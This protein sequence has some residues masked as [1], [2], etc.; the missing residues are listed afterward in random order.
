[1]SGTNAANQPSS[2][3]TLRTAAPS[4]VPGG[5]Q[6]SVS[7]IDSA[8]NFWFGDLWKYSAGEWTWMSGSN[9]VPQYGVYGTLGTPDPNN[10]PGGRKLSGGWID[11]TG[12]LW[13]FGGSGYRR[14]RLIHSM[15]CG[16]TSPEWLLHSQPANLRQR[17]RNANVSFAIPV[18]ISDYHM[19]LL[20][21][22]H[23][24]SQQLNLKRPITIP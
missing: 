4:N 9:I 7:W 24:R 12:N 15:I 8:G 6:G 5:R 22:G 21:N 16:G 19:R 20:R 23:N 1:M 11:A 2:Y 3:G 10:V 17:L 18:E 14:E 13:L